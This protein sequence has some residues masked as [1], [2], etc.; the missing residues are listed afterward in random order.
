[1]KTHQ[2]IL[3][4]GLGALTPTILNLLVIDLKALLLDLSPLP[5]LGYFIKVGI[6]FYLGGHGGLPS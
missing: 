2:K 1:M 3:I 5:F 4:G 6:L